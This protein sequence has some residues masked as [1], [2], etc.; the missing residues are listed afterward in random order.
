M[1]DFM[2]S[3][4]LSDFAAVAEGVYRRKPSSPAV[5][6]EGL[7]GSDMNTLY[8]L[9]AVVHHSGAGTFRDF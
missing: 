8:D 1:S 2:T 9:Y 6:P 4:R 7:A 3:T 5:S